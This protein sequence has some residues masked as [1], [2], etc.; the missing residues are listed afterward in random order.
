MNTNNEEAVVNN[1]INYKI[2]FFC[3]YLS[4]QNKHE[5]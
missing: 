5:I 1:C 2:A 3:I 4:E